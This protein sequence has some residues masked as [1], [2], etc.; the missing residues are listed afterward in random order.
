MTTLTAMNKFVQFDAADL[1]G[2]AGGAS[3]YPRSVHL[4]R[5]QALESGEKKWSLWAASLLILGISAAFWTGVA[6]LLF[7]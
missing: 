4:D 2:N 7:R 6:F 3:R 5:E 1:I